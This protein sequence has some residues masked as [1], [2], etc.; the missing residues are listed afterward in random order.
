[1]TQATGTTVFVRRFIGHEA[2]RQVTDAQATLA[3][4]QSVAL[5]MARHRVGWAW[6]T[7]CRSAGQIEAPTAQ[8][9]H[10]GSERHC[11]AARAERAGKRFWHQELH[12]PQYPQEQFTGCP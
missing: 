8:L 10:R 6:G 9:A 1:V 3:V 7:K 4:Q 11:H 2:Q 5:A 12:A